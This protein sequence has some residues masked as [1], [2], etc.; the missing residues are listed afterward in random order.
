MKFIEENE[1][2][3][4]EAL[5][6]SP[7]AYKQRVAAY[8]L[9]KR[10]AVNSDEPPSLEKRKAEENA[11][12]PVSVNAVTKQSAIGNAHLFENGLTKELKT[13][14]WK[15]MQQAAKAG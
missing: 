6:N 7:N 10:V 14:L 1:P 4:A 15:E 5:V 2:E 3:L 9:L 13:Q 12:K 11:Q 8:K